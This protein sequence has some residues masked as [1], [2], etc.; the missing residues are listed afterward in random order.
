MVAKEV[1]DPLGTEMGVI[2]DE[3]NYGREMS[4]SLKALAERMEMQDLRFLAVAVTIQQQA[5]GNLAETLANLATVLRMRGQM[6][7]KIK[8]M[9]SE[10]KASAYIVGSLPFIVFGMIWMINGSYMQGFFID[11]RLMV[12]GGGGLL[13]MGI[14]AFIMSK[15]VNFEI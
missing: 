7:L 4:D 1:P 10:S 13:W 9:S 8:A 5:G 14:G 12:A 6:K 2:A 11:Q 3:A 15:M